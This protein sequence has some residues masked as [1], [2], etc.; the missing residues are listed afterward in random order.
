MIL[1]AVEDLLVEHDPLLVT[2]EEV[3]KA[4]GIS[5]AL[6]HAYLGD[7]R[8]LID[9]LQLRLVGRLDDWL[10][11]GLARATSP[12][13][14]LHALSIGI[15]SFVEA[16]RDAWQVLVTTGGLDHPS[17]HAARSR[18]CGALDSGSGSLAPQL[19]VASL[20]SGAGGWVARGEDPI[21]VAGHLD[22]LLR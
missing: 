18:W 22:R 14:A 6:V 9:A 15:F 19:I 20:L 8:G 10:G 5:R 12:G 17:L 11:H 13:S 3:A 2:F 21:T 1:D 7:R 4:A 16:N